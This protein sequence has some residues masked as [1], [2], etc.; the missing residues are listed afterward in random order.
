MAQKDDQGAIALMDAPQIWLCTK[1]IAI[2]YH[3]CRSF[4]VKSDVD[5]NHVDTREHITDIFT[6]PLDTVLFENIRNKL[7]IWYKMATLLVS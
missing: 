2:N 3:H 4:V 7:N 5:T 1:H 6:N